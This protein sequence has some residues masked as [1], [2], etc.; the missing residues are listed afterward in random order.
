MP[1]PKKYVPPKLRSLPAYKPVSLA[2]KR[3][4]LTQEQLCEKVR[5]ENYG[6]ADAA[7]CD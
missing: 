1:E 3:T 5:R 4:P 7:W 2:L 6:K